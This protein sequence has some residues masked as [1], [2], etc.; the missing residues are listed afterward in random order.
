M[1]WFGQLRDTW[2]DDEGEPINFI[3]AGDRVVVRFIYRGAGHHGPNLNMEF[4]CVF[5]LRNGTI[6]GLDFFWNH[7]E[8][9]KAAGLR[10]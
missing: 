3:D 2:D 1:R 5:T 7:A 8:A 9:L 4:T 6:S 10:E